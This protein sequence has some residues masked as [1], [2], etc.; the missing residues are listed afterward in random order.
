[1]EKFIHTIGHSTHS[2]E[3]FI[4]LLTSFSIEL[5]V[6]I[7]RYPGSRRYPHFNSA[8]LATSL[9]ANEIGYMHMHDLGGRRSAQRDSPNSGW[10]NSSFRGYADYMQ[11]SPFLHAVDQLQNMA[12]KQRV[13]MMCSEAVW[14]SCHRSLVADYLK[15]KGWAVLHILAAGKQ[16]PHPYTS[17]AKVTEHGLSYRK[18]DDLFS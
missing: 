5:L 12:E 7:R 3:Y 2:I 11:T 14:W 8:E 4:G 15:W 6:D 9:A 10:R 1:M 16:Q 18:D 13:A 17:P